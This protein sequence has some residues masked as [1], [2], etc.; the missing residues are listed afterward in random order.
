VTEGALDRIRLSVPVI[1]A[2][3]DTPCL[4]MDLDVVEANAR[5]LQAAM[6]ARGVRLRPHAKTHKSVAL[7]RLQ[8]EEGAAGLTVGTLGEAETFAAAGMTDLFVAY[9]VWAVGPKASR[10][11]AVHDTSDLAVGFDSVAGAERLAAAVA[12]SDRPLRVRIEID[13]GGHR[14]GVGSSERAADIA[15]AATDLGLVVDGAFTHGGHGYAGPEA[16][17]AAA[18]DEIRA[19][20][21]AA[22][23]L[24]AVGIDVAIVS[25]GS[26]PTM[27]D[28]AAGRVNEIR[29]GT[30]LLGDRHEVALGAIAA[31]ALAAH[32]AATVISTAVPGQVVIDAGAKSLTKD[33][34]P[35]VE[36]FGALP[37][38]PEATIDRL[39]DYHAVVHIP[40]GTPGPHLGEVVAVAPNHICPVVD[41]FDDFAVTRSGRLEG[42]W[43]VDARGRSG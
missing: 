41:L 22:D 35:Y 21:A 23:A 34:A 1:P 20:T 25:A 11:R 36:G 2:G 15:R 31:D 29:A 7:G 26:T 13:S 27:I 14:S 43:P 42:R 12:G 19:L 16:R 24:A 4:V 40:P 32:I 30:Y 9:P 10:L 3:L 18:A 5:R 6:D 39:Y 8:L 28:A 37:G 33:R 38:Y 17:G